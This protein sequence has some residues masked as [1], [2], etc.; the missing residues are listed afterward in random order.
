M[1]WRPYFFKGIYCK[2]VLPY[3][4]LW[5]MTWQY[6][7]TIIII[8]RPY[9]TRNLVDIQP[10]EI[11]LQEKWTFKLDGVG[12]SPHPPITN[13]TRKYKKNLDSLQD[14][15]VVFKTENC[16]KTNTKLRCIVGLKQSLLT[17]WSF[18]MGGM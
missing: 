1:K 5:K 17:S 6:L 7:C 13:T 14:S 12:Q 8:M 9:K 4:H 2:I 10:F 3:R 11:N 15:V 16:V 18:W